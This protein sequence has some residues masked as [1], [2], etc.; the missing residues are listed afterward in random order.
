MSAGRDGGA[1]GPGPA[2]GSLQAS[3]S[4]SSCPARKRRLTA[5]LATGL[6][7]WSLPVASQ[8]AAPCA[9]GAL[10]LPC[11]EMEQATGERPCEAARQRFQELEDR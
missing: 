2:G 4:V 11:E 3:S 8:P 7:D 6:G 10:E 9:P 1:P 5:A